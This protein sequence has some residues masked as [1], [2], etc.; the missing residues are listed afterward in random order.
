M[1]TLRQF[2]LSS[3]VAA[4][5]CMPL[6]AQLSPGQIRSL[7]E[8][9][10]VPSIELFREYLGLPNDAHSAEDIHRPLPSL[11]VARTERRFTP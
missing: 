1:P 6:S 8:A 10:A 3:V 4:L 2:V 7:V 11:D 9:E 5:A